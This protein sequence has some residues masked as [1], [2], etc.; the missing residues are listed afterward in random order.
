M[1]KAERA[2]N[3]WVVPSNY[4]GCSCEACDVAVRVA[5]NKI[6]VVDSLLARDFERQLHTSFWGGGD[7]SFENTVRMQQSCTISKTQRFNI[8]PN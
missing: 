4:V 5:P 8:K 7:Y 2:D 6:E 3:I 1:R